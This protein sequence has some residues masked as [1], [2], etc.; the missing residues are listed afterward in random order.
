[1]M[2]ESMIRRAKDQA[3]EL[4][5]KAYQKAAEEG[6]L[7]AGA[8]LRAAVEIPKDTSHGDYASSYALAAAKALGQPP[9]VI[10]QAILDRLELAGSYFDRAEIA[11]PGFLN[12]TLGHKWSH[13]VLATI[14]EQGENYGK[15]DVGAGKRFMVEFVS[16]N[17]TGPMHMGNA[18]GGVLGDS[19]ANVLAWAGYDTWKEFYV[20]DAGNQ[21]HK[22]AVSIDARYRQLILGED[23]VEFPE[24]GYHGEDIAEL[25][26][27]FLRREGESWIREDEQVRLDALARYGLAVNIPKMKEDL[28]KY[29]IEYDKWFLESTLHETGA[30]EA[31]VAE[32]TAKGYTYERD[33][34]LWLNTTQLLKEKYLREGKTQEQVDALDLKDDVLRRANGFYTYFA[35]DIA[36]H[37]N[38]LQE[39]GF[40]KAIN[41]W[42]ADHHGH[43]H[44]LQAALDGLGLD[45]SNRLVIVLMQLVNLLQDGKPVRM[46]K[47]SGKAIALH[48]LLDEV[49]VDAA[50]FFF[51]NSSPTRP[52]D[53]D[54]DLAVRQDS[55]NPVYYVQYAHAR[56]CSLIRKLKEDGAVIPAAGD[57]DASI[58]V[59][60]EEKALVKALAQLPEEV[61]MVAADLDPSHIN[62]YLTSLAGD[63]HRFY[64]ACRI[65]GEEKAVL[66]ARLKMVDSVRQVLAVSM[67]LLGVKAPEKM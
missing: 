19:L 53:F 38:K 5:E 40:D 30:V 29:G 20:N 21:I 67:G 24:D 65:K 37:R 28:K 3:A 41:I 32:L 7:P 11:G 25:A 43:V 6:V 62:R 48:D 18:R 33:G 9:R 13:D 39:R 61:R 4:I 64:N 16:A 55:E 44:R 15:C 50:R 23:Q 42:G 34:A 49:S 56:I 57:V 51:N 63:F 2:T 60:A 47:R 26:M 12:F 22:F 1:M 59:T 66:E 54:L 46:S 17:P 14:E 27:D 31:A 58:F 35:A 52:V 36:Y 45:G 10:A 8:Q